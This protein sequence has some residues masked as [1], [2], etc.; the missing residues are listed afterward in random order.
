MGISQES[1]QNQRWDQSKSYVGSERTRGG[2]D[3]DVGVADCA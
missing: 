2:E 1:I 3:E